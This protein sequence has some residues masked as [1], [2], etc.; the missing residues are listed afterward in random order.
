MPLERVSVTEDIAIGGLP[1]GQMPVSSSV[2]GL[3][4]RYAGEDRLSS[5]FEA[6]Y[7]ADSIGPGAS[8]IGRIMLSVACPALIGTR[9]GCDI[10]LT[11]YAL[12]QGLMMRRV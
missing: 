10:T 7:D 8:R 1:Y 5:P 4:L 2:I 9:V 6:V 11:T 3:R 12:L